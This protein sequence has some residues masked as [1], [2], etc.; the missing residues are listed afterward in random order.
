MFKV[1]LHCKEDLRYSSDLQTK[2]RYEFNDDWP[3]WW[4]YAYQDDDMPTFYE[5]NQSKSY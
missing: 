2:K 1:S 3:Q 4:L 5:K